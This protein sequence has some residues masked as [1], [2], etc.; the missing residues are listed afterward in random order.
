LLTPGAT[1][2]VVNAPSTVSTINDINGVAVYDIYTDASKDVYYFSRLGPNLSVYID[3]NSNPIQ[4][5]TNGQTYIA[6]LANYVPSPDGTLMYCILPPNAYSTVTATGSGATVGNPTN[7]T[8]ITTVVQPTISTTITNPSTVTTTIGN[9]TGTTTLTDT[10]LA[11][12][13]TPNTFPNSS[14][15]G[16]YDGNNSIVQSPVDLRTAWS[17]YLVSSFS[18]NMTGTASV[19]GTAPFFNSLPATVNGVTNPG[20]TGLEIAFNQNRP[21]ATNV[22]GYVLTQSVLQ[23]PALSSQSE[24][25]A[26]LEVYK[27]LSL[28]DLFP[29]GD[30]EILKQF[31]INLYPTAQFNLV[32]PTQ[33]SDIQ[34][35]LTKNI[36][37]FF[38]I[39]Q[40]TLIPQ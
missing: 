18:S 29:T 33:D 38:N 25:N 22:S 11:Y 34:S 7:I 1:P 5:T 40:Q 6:I 36:I 15:I 26:D 13:P 24:I 31:M 2:G 32:G 27:S 4:Y 35:V 19:N 37:T 3:V 17:Y 30:P 14:Y 23:Y 39:Q 9:P 28:F 21:G 12:D 10:D 8:T 16:N 20:Y